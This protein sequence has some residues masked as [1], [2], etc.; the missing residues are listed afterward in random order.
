MDTRKNNHGAEA[1]RQDKS[2]DIRELV[3]IIVK[4]LVDYPDQV[5]CHEVEGTYSC[6]LELEV[7]KEDIGKVIGK[8][9]AHADAIR[10]IIHAVGGKKKRRYVLEILEDK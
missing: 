1:T 4:A 10:R 2:V 8:Q 3:E 9:G 5:R 6:V 7:A